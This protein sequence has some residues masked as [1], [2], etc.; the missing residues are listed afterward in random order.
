MNHQ[1]NRMTPRRGVE[2][3]MIEATTLMKNI[4]KLAKANNSYPRVYVY[5]LNKIASD[6]L[7]ISS[8]ASDSK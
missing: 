8:I 7:V 2:S 1:F 4:E 6:Y 5:Y 3:L